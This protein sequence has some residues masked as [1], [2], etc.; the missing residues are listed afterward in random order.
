MFIAV[1]FVE[2]ALASKLSSLGKMDNGAGPIFTSLT[3]AVTIRWS[4]V[5]DAEKHNPGFL[6]LRFRFFPDLCEYSGQR[7][8][9]SFVIQRHPE[10]ERTARLGVFACLGSA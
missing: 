5:C 6:F 7:I 1:H 8:D 9:E 4:P 2:S 10:K 3:S